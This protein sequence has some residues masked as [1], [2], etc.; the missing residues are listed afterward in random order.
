MLEGAAVTCQIGSLPASS[1]QTLRISGMVIGDVESELAT[2]AVINPT[3]VNWPE[4]HPLDNTDAA[5]V[6][7]GYTSLALMEDFENGLSAGWS[8]G[9]LITT[10]SGEKVCESA[11]PASQS[12]QLLIDPIAP[13][14]RI[15]VGF[16]LYII[17]PWQG[18]GEDGV[19]LPAFFDFG[20][21]G[22]NAKITTTFCNLETCTQAYP[23][24]YPLSTYPAFFGSEAIGELGF[25]PD[26][27]T[28]ARYH[29][30]LSFPH[31]QE[32]IDLTWLAENLPAEARFG[33]DY[34]VVILDSGW[35]WIYLPNI[36]R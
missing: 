21:T 35:N 15:K 33:L 4:I 31:E 16:D 10:P 11:Y 12:I 23:G 5:S 13:H 32:L 27:I 18:N 2:T 3:L 30:E 17:G 7:I 8:G 29:I 6:Q 36:T 28:E 22:Q 19:S 26:T 9:N 24:R 20:V 1:E 25:D 34:V 14:K